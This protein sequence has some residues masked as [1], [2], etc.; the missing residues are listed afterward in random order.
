MAVVGN[1]Q[2]TTTTT[3]TVTTTPAATT[4]ETFV[5]T[6]DHTVI[7]SGSGSFPGYLMPLSVLVSVSVCWPKCGD[8]LQLGRHGIP[9]V[10]KCAGGRQSCMIHR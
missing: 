3:T 10:D 4:T 7:A 2:I 5:K 9:S 8:A 1:V 6:E